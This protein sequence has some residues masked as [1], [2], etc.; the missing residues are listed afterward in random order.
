MRRLLQRYDVAT[1]WVDLVIVAVAYVAVVGRGPVA[2][3][4]GPDGRLPDAGAALGALA[5]VAFGLLIRARYAGASRRWTGFGQEVSALAQV[6]VAGSIVV[7]GGALALFAHG[8][9]LTAL[10]PFPAL[11]FLLLLSAHSITRY[12]LGRL[13]RAGRNLRYVLVVGDGR[14]EGEYVRRVRAN[15]HLGL[16]VTRVLAAH[17]ASGP[18]QAELLAAMH[19]GPVDS[20]VVALPV[21]HG[22]LPEAVT[23]AEREGKDVRVLLDGFGARLSA[24]TA[25]NFLGLPMIAFA[26]AGAGAGTD[27]AAA[28]AVKRSLDVVGAVAA[29][30]VLAPFALAA[31]LAIKLDDPRAPVL[32][33]QVRVGLN[34][35]RFT[36]F[37][38][39]TMHS[40]ADALTA[41]LQTANEMDGPVFKIRRD[42]R[43]TRPGRVLR[44]LSLDE[45]PQ[46]WN[47]L[48][49]DMSLVGPRPPLPAEVES[50][51][52]H[53]Y[54]RRLAVRPGLTGPWQVSGRNEVPF[55][56][57]MELDLEY[58]DHWSLGRDLAILAQTVTAVVTG[59]GAS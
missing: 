13:R 4:L 38:L 52:R 49:G 10:L 23:M 35:R 22:A 9:A 47:V 20:V 40:G 53:D 59:R 16:R 54:R 7:L 55:E 15:A 24:G 46:L 11:V 36:L 17:A 21:T 45:Y 42:P 5:V 18:W 27:A 6:T 1:T 29:A 58:V 30:I 28:V 31:A 50:Y 26:P 19:D 3:W 12:A 33:R 41:L 57:W 48:R 43:V 25:S 44:R 37:K 8:G 51:A 56:R 32:Y 2:A 34:G 14:T 39:R